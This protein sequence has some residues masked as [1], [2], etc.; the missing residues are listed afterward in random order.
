MYV[1][2]LAFEFFTDEPQELFQHQ[3]E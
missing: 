3:Y 2:I 1:V